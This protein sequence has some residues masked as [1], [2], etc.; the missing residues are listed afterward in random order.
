MLYTHVD[1][2]VWVCKC[3]L[4]SLYDIC[5][6]VRVMNISIPVEP[7]KPVGFCM[8]FSVFLA[9]QLASYAGRTGGWAGRT[10]ISSL[11]KKKNKNLLTSM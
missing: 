11:K 6:V 3:A 5:I 10:R 2:S 8:S 9:S 4:I 1:M 7:A